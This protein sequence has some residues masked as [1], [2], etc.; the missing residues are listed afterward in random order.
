ML[1]GKQKGMQISA[2]MAII[3]LILEIKQYYGIEAQEQWALNAA[4]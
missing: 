4:K 2:F 3:C 1:P